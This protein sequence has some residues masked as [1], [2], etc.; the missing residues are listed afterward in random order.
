MSN[1]RLPIGV[2]GGGPGGLAAA[3]TLAARGHSVVVYE[4]R[5]RT[6]G[7]AGTIE[8]DGF[9]FD[10]GPT[11]L[12]MPR[13]FERIFA[14]ADRDFGDYVAL[15][16][17]AP[18]WRGFLPGG[19]TRDLPADPDAASA[20]FG[21]LL[22]L[23]RRM[24]AAA[25]RRLFWRP[26]GRLAD[27]VGGAA[28][29]PL[30]AL[31]D[32]ATLRIGRSLGGVVASHVRDDGMAGLLQ[33]FATANGMLPVE[34]PAL[35]CARFAEA[36]EG[37]S[38]YP[39]GGMAALVAALETLARDLGVAFRTRTPVA[40]IA[41][42]RRRVIGLVTEKGEMQPL[43]AIVSAVD[44]DRTYRELVGDRLGRSLAGGRRP[45]RQR[46]AFL[47]C[48]GL[49]RRYPHL[50]HE[51]VVF[52]AAGDG[53]AEDPTCHV[54][55]PAGADPS[56]APSDGEALRVLVHV[57]PCRAGDDWAV[58]APAWRRRILD[59]L[60]RDAGLSDL[61]KRI[62]RER[63]VTPADFAA[64]FGMDGALDG[65]RGRTRFRGALRPGN[66]CRL[67]DGLYLAG[68]TAHPGP[69]VSSAAMS[70]WIAADALHRDRIRAAAGQG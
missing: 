31:S 26:V 7:K 60:A 8:V 53:T 23:S 35:V 47:L 51:N 54:T 24:R 39:R 67:V 40:R 52:S 28:G 61:D 12:V 63:I 29:G 33:T 20:A 62:V 38:W 58:L 49:D 59:K 11:S 46:S 34:A 21:G 5:G 13:V 30:A 19:E 9:R 2:I 32:L 41:V 55:A 50:A 42:D 6:G 65:N 3:C 56:A 22:E 1:R 18:L 16:R 27:M 48:L 37:G 70:G 4:A 66:R 45:A 57:P 14:E 15:E 43:S 64:R 68:E 10:A 44:S 69:G 25:E 17:L 36:L